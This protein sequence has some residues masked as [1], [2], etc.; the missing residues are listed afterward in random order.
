MSGVATVKSCA[1]CGGASFSLYERGMYA[2]DGELLDLLRCRCGFVFVSPRPTAERLRAL[3]ASEKYYETDYTLGVAGSS[4]FAR[5]DELLRIYDKVVRDLERTEKPGRIFEVGAAGGFFL[6]AARRRGW[7]ASGVEISP[8][9]AEYARREFGIDVQTGDV[10]EAHVPPGSQDVVYVDNILEH[11]IDPVDVLRRLLAML[12]AG[13]LLV[14]IVPTYVNSIY[15]RVLKV[16]RGGTL[17]RVLAPGR[18]GAILKLRASEPSPPYHI[19]EFTLPVLRSMVAKAGF[20]V[21]RL[22]GSVPIPD[23][24]ENGGAGGAATL[25]QK[26]AFRSADAL[27]RAGILPG[28]RVE[29]HARRLRG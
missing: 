17:G 15:F 5:R 9:A 8:F 27:M 14:V 7:N 20:S 13:G 21:E 28:A 29:V 22:E 3:Y 24:L 18:L 16:L 11:T 1:L 6:E 26:A 23:Y 4:Y 19:D 25:L 2:L 10:T 12:R